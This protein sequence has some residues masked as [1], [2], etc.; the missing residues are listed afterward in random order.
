LKIKN[1][2]EEVRK[3]NV[4]LTDHKYKYTLLQE[5][6]DIVLS[7]IAKIGFL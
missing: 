6:Y 4:K 3:I 1:L 5:N 2:E 7:K